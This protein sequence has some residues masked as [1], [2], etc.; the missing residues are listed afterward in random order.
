METG[1]TFRA[2]FARDNTDTDSTFAA[3]E[4]STTDVL[5]LSYKQPLLRGA[6]R[7]YAT[8][9]QRAADLAWKR[10]S[11]RERQVRHTLIR[12]GWLRSA[13][14]SRDGPVPYRSNAWYISAW[15]NSI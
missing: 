15:R 9:Q 5:T 12:D 6:W 3:Q 2:A 4:T 8:V 7:E 1:G 13:L 14:Q 11:E 10:Q